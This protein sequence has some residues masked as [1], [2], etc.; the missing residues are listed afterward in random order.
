VYDGD[1]AQQTPIEKAASAVG[2]AAKLAAV[3]GVSV[4]AVGNWRARG[5]PVIHCMA[6]EDATNRVVTRRELRPDD[7]QFYWPDLKKAAR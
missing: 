2:G 4:Q 6:I 1:M 5:V 7:W 3:L